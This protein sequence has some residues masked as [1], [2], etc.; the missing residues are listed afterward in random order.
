MS[1]ANA[2]EQQK[3]CP[4]EAKPER[5]ATPCMIDFTSFLIIPKAIRWSPYLQQQVFSKVARLIVGT[6]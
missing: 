6:E 3:N 4:V 2:K 1:T 5:A